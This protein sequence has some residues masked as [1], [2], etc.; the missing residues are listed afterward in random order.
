MTDRT[1][2]FLACYPAG[3]YGLNYKSVAV[4]TRCSE[5]VRGKGSWPS[6]S[7]CTRANGH[8][9]HGAW[10]KQHNPEA[11]KAKR[12]ARDKAWKA[13][14]AAERREGAFKAECQSAIRA[15]ASGHNDPRELAQ[16]IID[17]LEA[18]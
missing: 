8:G 14:W 17:R 16:G 9:P 3:G 4:L 13:K 2:E 11:V 12:E 10:C 1:P 7:Q 6:Y 15:I 5:N 18:K